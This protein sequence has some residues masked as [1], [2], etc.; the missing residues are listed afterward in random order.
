LP[1]LPSKARNSDA[2]HVLS[3][4]ASVPDTVK[5][6]ELSGKSAI[7]D[8][9]THII[10]QAL[11]RVPVGVRLLKK[12]NAKRENESADESN[13]PTILV[14]LSYPPS[15]GTS[16]DIIEVPQ[17]NPVLIELSWQNERD[18]QFER[19]SIEPQQTLRVEVGSS[20]LTLRTALGDLHR[21][22]PRMDYDF[23][24]YFNPVD[25]VLAENLTERLS[26]EVYQ[27]RPL[28]V[29][30]PYVGIDPDATVTQVLETPLRVSRKVGLLLSPESA[31]KDFDD[32]LSF[33]AKRL[34]TREMLSWIIPIH[35][36]PV[37]IPPVLRSASAVDLGVNS[38]FESGYQQLLRAITGERK[39]TT[40]QVVQPEPATAKA[41][42]VTPRIKLPARIFL[43]Y[44]HDDQRYIDEFLR[45]LE[46][47]EREGI[48]STLRDDSPLKPGTLWE[49]EIRKQLERADI[50]LM[51][52]SPDY[53]TGT[54]TQQEI[55]LALNRRKSGDVLVIPVIVSP[56]DWMSSGLGLIQAL[57]TG[58]QPITKWPNRD[59]AYKNIIDGIRQAITRR[60]AGDEEENV[61]DD[62]FKPGVYRWPVRTASDEDVAKINSS[63][64]KTTI[65]ALSKQPR[66]L[67]MPLRA[68][69]IP[70]Y[71]T[72]RATPI[73]TTRWSVETH[74]TAY[75]RQTSGGYRMTLQDTEGITIIAVAQDPSILRSSSPLSAEMASVVRK[76]TTRF[77]FGPTFTKTNVPVR[78]V[79]LG[80]FNRWHVQS[81]GAPNMLEL[82]PLLDIEFLEDD[83]RSLTPQVTTIETTFRGFMGSERGAFNEGNIRDVFGD[84]DT[85]LRLTQARVYRLGPGELKL[86][87]RVEGPPNMRNFAKVARQTLDKA[88]ARIGPPANFGGGMASQVSRT[89]SKSRAVKSRSKP[90]VARKS[91]KVSRKAAAKKPTLKKR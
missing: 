25:R 81:P 8:K 20:E 79:G 62:E 27:D 38:D 74:I 72:R 56:A 33:A 26:A 41:T 58:A 88:I 34:D 18:R 85:E 28:K 32:I 39:Q 48:I 12:Q 71:Q 15:A 65:E 16:P 17:T 90:Q 91:K 53:L 6:A 68:V 57:P 23:F 63:I 73:E 52:V 2:A 83:R 75:K 22:E 24:L 10:T 55:E 5:L 36:R 87:A 49:A 46:T 9:L 67:D 70:N 1:T 66:P 86:V 50:I 4:V 59:T 43:S 45:H 11:P 14:E 82:Q 76:L 80:F 61:P 89:V 7:N 77:K 29:Y 35:H 54:F 19:V 21:L 69:R 31:E 78:V 44:S 51:F 84:L 37:E 30:M 40:E 64:V 13:K 42:P 3:L 47:L 60:N